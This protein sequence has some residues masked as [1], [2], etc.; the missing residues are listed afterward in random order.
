M[1]LDELVGVHGGLEKG[2][3]DCSLC[4]KELLQGSK[5]HD[6]S[7]TTSDGKGVR[8]PKIDVPYQRSSKY[9]CICS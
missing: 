5:G 2:I 6:S 1:A 8:L 3:F 4:I 7:Y 9:V